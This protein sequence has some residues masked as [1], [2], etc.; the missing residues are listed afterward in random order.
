M[1]AIE[2]SSQLQDILKEHRSKGEKIGFV[3]TMGALHEGHLKL[4]KQAQKEN[5]MVVV[6][7]FVN[8]TQFNNPNDL[9]NYPR[10]L[11]V[12][13]KKCEDVNVDYVFTPSEQEIYPTSDKRVFDFGILDKVMEGEHR[14]GHFNGVAQVVSRLFDIVKP[15]SAY[16]GQ[17]DFQQL[18]VIR[19]MIADYNYNINIVACPTV[20]ENDGLAMSSRNALL[21]TKHRENAPIIAQTLFAARNKMHEFSVKETI[22]WVV[23]QINSNPLL[24]VEYFEIANAQTLEPLSSWDEA[25]S[26]V[27]CIAVQ[28]GDVRLI[29]NVLFKTDK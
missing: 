22:R 11:E 18:A 10:T 28:A 21:T 14:P 27:G 8:P 4:V 17:K 26:I 1:I 19:K 15:T 16:F 5:H 13:L 3:P 24:N 2:T 20:R 29:D 12:D 25:K 9:R 7:I 23:N 6:S